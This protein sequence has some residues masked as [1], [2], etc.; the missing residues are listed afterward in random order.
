MRAVGTRSA[1]YERRGLRPGDR[2]FLHSGN[3]L[4]FFAELLAVWR[5]GGCAVP[6]DGRLTRV[7]LERLVDAAAPRFSMVDDATDAAVAAATAGIISGDSKE[8]FYF[9]NGFALRYHLDEGRAE[10]PAV[11]G[12]D[13]HPADLSA[14]HPEVADRPI[15]ENRVFPRTP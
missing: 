6:V 14:E 8:T 1:C 2:V 15:R 9:K 5:L 11:E 13:M 3:R 12:D 10:L 7:E 4:E